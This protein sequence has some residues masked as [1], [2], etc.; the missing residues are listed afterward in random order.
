MK[1]GSIYWV[2]LG[3]SHPPEFGKTR[4]GLVISN[5]IQNSILDSVVVVPLSSRPGEIWPLRLPLTGVKGKISF[6]VLPG[7]RQVSK[8]R[9]VKPMGFATSDFMSSLDEALLLYLSD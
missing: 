3:A 4:P 9:L 2:N 8:S 1:R 7:I 6:A 5:S